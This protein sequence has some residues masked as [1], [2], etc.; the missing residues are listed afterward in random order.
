MSDLKPPRG[1]TD[2]LPELKRRHRHIEESARGISEL[3][4]FHEISTPIFESSEVFTRT[5]G[6]TSDVVTKE[7]YTFEDKKGRN[8]SLRPEG[9][10]GVAR[11]FIS[12]MRSEPLPLKLFYQGPMFRYE[13][14]QK[15]RQ[16]QFHQFGVELLGVYS[17]RSC[18]R[19][20]RF[21]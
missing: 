2:L 12:E 8:L 11:A 19:G 17:R 1:T 7:M 3:Y 13:R 10:A 9:T 16:R 6:E 4:G 21:N 5:L 15:G 20:A 14:A 18:S